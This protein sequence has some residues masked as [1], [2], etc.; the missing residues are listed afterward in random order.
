MEPVT[1]SRPKAQEARRPDDFVRLDFSSLRRAQL[2]LNVYA[3]I[4]LMRE[5][6]DHLKTMEVATAR[7]QGRP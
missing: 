7:R 1:A 4:S 3:V 2:D 5:T 6:G